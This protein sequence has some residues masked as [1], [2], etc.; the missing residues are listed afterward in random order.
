MITHR[1]K[2]Q[3]TRKQRHQ[4]KASVKLSDESQLTIGRSIVSIECLKP[5]KKD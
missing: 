2:I 5:N 3:A 4:G 1:A